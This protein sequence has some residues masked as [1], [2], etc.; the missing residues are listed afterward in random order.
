MRIAQ[1]VLQRVPRIRWEESADL[2]ATSRGPG[3]F[4]H[5]GIE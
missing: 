4:G 1:L 2:A 3:G 5:T